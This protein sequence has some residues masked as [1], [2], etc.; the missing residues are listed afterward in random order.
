[1]DR[2]ASPSKS[3]RVSLRVGGP[4]VFLALSSLGGL[5]ASLFLYFAPDWVYGTPLSWGWRALVLPLGV[6]MGAMGL[7]RREMSQERLGVMDEQQSS[8]EALQDF[9]Q[10][11]AK[12]ESE[13]EIA[14]GV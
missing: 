7:R 9:D 4:V 5:I 3:R 14:G 1:M 12:K 6:L 2:K 11:G 10:I 8:P 13:H